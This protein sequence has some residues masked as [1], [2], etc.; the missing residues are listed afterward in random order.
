MERMPVRDPVEVGV[1]VTLI[2]QLELAAT[3]LPQ[4]LV[5]LKSPLVVILLIVSAPPP[6]FESVT[7]WEAEVVP[8]T[9][10]PKLNEIGEMLPRP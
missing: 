7:C 8:I 5:W 2:W 6:V 4:L 3:E 10:L 1:K 9:K